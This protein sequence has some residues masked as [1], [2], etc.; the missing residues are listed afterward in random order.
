MKKPA[1]EHGDERV[2][3]T[4]KV[5]SLQDDLL[6]AV[7]M[8]VY[9]GRLIQRDPERLN[10]RRYTNNGARSLSHLSNLAL[11]PALQD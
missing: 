7:A 5:G 10:T 11:R 9:T 2:K 4:G 6:I 3:L 8:C 1:N